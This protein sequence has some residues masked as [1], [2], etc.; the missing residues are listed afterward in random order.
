MDSHHIHLMVETLLAMVAASIQMEGECLKQ[1]CIPLPTT[2]M[3]ING[4]PNNRRTKRE[5]I[6]EFPVHGRVLQADVPCCE[7][8]APRAR[9]KNN[10]VA[11]TAPIMIMT[12]TAAAPPDT[13]ELSTIDFAAAVRMAEPSSFPILAKAPLFTAPLSPAPFSLPRGL[14]QKY[15]SGAWQ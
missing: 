1:R 14:L 13:S 5:D 3:G 6:C 12:S 2:R 11:A 9:Y 10:P 7:R 4:H 15:E 8:F